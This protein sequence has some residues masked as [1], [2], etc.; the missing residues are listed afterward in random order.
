MIEFGQPAERG[1][2]AID[3]FRRAADSLSS[4]CRSEVECDLSARLPARFA[5]APGVGVRHTVMFDFRP[6][7]SPEARERNVAAIRGMGKLPMVLRY[8]VQRTSAYG[9]DPRQMEWQ[10][11][12]DFAT[13]DDYH[14]YSTA[15][16]HLAIRDDF[17]A[18]TSRVAFLDVRL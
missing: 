18:H 16:V 14:A 1:S 6:D 8:V 15:P 4:Q 3:A 7:A 17:T 5:D 11:I 12:G 2:A 13:V 9:D 10:V